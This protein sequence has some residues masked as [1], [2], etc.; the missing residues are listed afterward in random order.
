MKS[1]VG[2]LISISV[3]LLNG[4]SLGTKFLNDLQKANMINAA[5]DVISVKGD[6]SGVIS[7]EKYQRLTDETNK[8]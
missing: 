6:V 4:K 2:F 7:A 8:G 3:G 1:L 5:D